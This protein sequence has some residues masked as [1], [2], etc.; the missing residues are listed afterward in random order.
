MA[1]AF[2]GCGG[3]ASGVALFT[4]PQG[5][6]NECSGTWESLPGHAWNGKFWAETKQHELRRQVAQPKMEGKKPAAKVKT[7]REE[8]ASSGDESDV[9]PLRKKFKAAVKQAAADGSRYGPGR[10]A[11]MLRMQPVW[12]L[13]QR[14]PRRRREGTER[15]LPGAA[16]TEATTSAGKR[17][18]GTVEGLPCPV[19][20][21]HPQWQLPAASSGGRDRQAVAATQEQNA[22]RQHGQV[23]DDGG[24]EEGQERRRAKRG[25]AADDAARKKVTGIRPG[26]SGSVTSTGA[27]RPTRTV[28]F[29]AEPTVFVMDK[30]LQH[31]ATDAAERDDRRAAV[32]V[33]TVRPTLASTRY[34]SEE[35]EA[36]LRARSG[37]GTE[38]R[39]AG[40]GAELGRT[41]E[42]AAAPPTE[43]VDGVKRRTTMTSPLDDGGR[44][45]MARTTEITEAAELESESTMPS[46]T[47]DGTNKGAD[48]DAATTASGDVTTTSPPDVTDT[49]GTDTRVRTTAGVD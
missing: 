6:W 45:M 13:R 19:A 4:N 31:M 48:P 25:S 49:P 29:E 12:V 36:Q 32:Y 35:R 21:R 44:R 15:R 43:R 24:A 11:E 23:A 20:I 34:A 33:A 5:V 40:E 1:N 7:K 3:E 2:E 14:V 9:K 16:R 8:F 47:E 17:R 39:S 38:T 46:P 26:T 37:E 18:P 30:V 28:R 22:T 27:K 10:A 41:G 42:G